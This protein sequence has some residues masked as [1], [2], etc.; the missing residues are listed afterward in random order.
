MSTTYDRDLTVWAK[1]TAQLL[2][3]RCWDAID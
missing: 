3:E 2:R 1:D